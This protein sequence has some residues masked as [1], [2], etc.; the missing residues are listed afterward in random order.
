MPYMDPRPH[1]EESAGDGP[2][3]A[4]AL[5]AGHDVDPDVLQHMAADEATRHRDEDPFTDR[6]TTVGDHRVVVNRS[7]FELDLNRPRH[8]AIYA[9]PGTAWGIE[10]WRTA[11]PDD[12]RRGNLLVHDSFYRRMR[13]LIESR[14][15]H[16]RRI[17]V[18]DLHS[19]CHRRSGPHALP[20]DPAGAPEINVCT[21]SIDRDRWGYLLDR[22]DDDLARPVHG[23]S[24]DVRENVR[25]DGGTFV[26]WVNG[27]FGDRVCAVQI[28]VKKIFMDEWTGELFED[29]HAAVGQALLAGARGVRE[30]LR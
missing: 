22:L 5:H 20:D 2:I 26:R 9:S 8:A 25:F 13:E 16:H 15:C 14:L 11:L 28:E 27:T 4:T 1:W 23:R 10:V 17:A 7:R 3:V 29:V 21:A 6:W 18:L 24:F 12:L 19:Y 30:S